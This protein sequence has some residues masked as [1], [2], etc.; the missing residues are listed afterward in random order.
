MYVCNHVHLSTSL[1]L[2][3][4]ICVFENVPVS[5]AFLI[6]PQAEYTPGAAQT[7]FA[8]RFRHLKGT[9]VKTVGEAFAEFTK[10]LGTPINA[11][12]KNMM[13]DIVG[14][15][16]LTVVNARFVR[17]PVWSLGMITALDLLLKNYPEKE[18][19]GRIISALFECCGLDEQAV[20]SEAAALKEWAVG[21]SREE[22]AAALRG[23][24]DGPIAPIAKAAKGDEFWMYSRFFG[25]GLIS[26][27]EDC[28][29]EMNA[30]DV[31][32]VMEDWMTN[33]LGK[34]HFTA[35]VSYWN[36]EMM[37]MPLLVCVSFF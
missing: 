26:L 2:G 19:T 34:S 31:Y 24:G 15:T 3:S 37:N 9:E 12:Y 29:V 35:C 22:I 21:K 6:S 28:G 16:H 30:D 8:E 27:M 10:I 14:T 1:C 32:P 25:I 23:E 13:T 36:M 4:H 18:T 20:R 33:C 11:L 7:S 5:F 17:D